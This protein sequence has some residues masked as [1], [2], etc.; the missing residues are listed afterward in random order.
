MPRR[1]SSKTRDQIGHTS[2]SEAAILQEQGVPQE[3]GIVVLESADKRV[4][5]CRVN[6]VHYLGHSIKVEERLVN[7]VRETLLNAGFKLK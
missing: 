5:E 1:K 6:G 2:E 7:G 3:G 4:L